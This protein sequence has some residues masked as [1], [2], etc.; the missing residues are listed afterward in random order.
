MA[1]PAEFPLAKS[2]A[3]WRSQLSGSEYRMLRQQGTEAPG[4]GEYFKFFPKEGYFGCRACK[5]PL[6][7]STSK[8][9]DCGWDAF[10]QCYFT[11]DTCHVGMKPDGGSIEIICSGCGSHLGHGALRLHLSFTP[12]PA[13]A[14]AGATPRAVTGLDPDD[15]TVRAPTLQLRLHLH[16]HLSLA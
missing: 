13:A 10:D 16:L 14:P 12:A 11:G 15:P 9:K 1:K 5:H 2:E 8:F 3:E 4:R 6:Y 7:S